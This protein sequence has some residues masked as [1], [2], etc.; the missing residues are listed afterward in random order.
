MHGVILPLHQYAFMSW[1]SV[2]K[3]AGIIL[4]LPLP[5]LLPDKFISE[6]FINTKRKC[7]YFLL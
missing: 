1:S 2:K 6:Q 7:N 3:C 4:P 5:L